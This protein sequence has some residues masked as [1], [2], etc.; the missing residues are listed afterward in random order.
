M[1]KTQS[2][3]HFHS[4]KNKEQNIVPFATKDQRNNQEMKINENIYDAKKP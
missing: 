3:T 2:P 1:N 4:I